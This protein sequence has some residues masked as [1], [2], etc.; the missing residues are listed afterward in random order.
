MPE[1]EEELQLDE[2]G[3]ESRRAEG[4]AGMDGDSGRELRKKTRFEVLDA[5]KGLR[6]EGGG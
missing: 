5:V 6:L 1:A 3:Y 2:G 4:A